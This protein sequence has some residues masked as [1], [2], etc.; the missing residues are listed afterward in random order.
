[1]LTY[2]NRLRGETYQK[3]FI[4]KTKIG[5]FNGKNVI[6][7]NNEKFKKQ[8]FKIY[9]KI[10][11]KNFKKIMKYNL[12]IEKKIILMMIRMILMMIFFI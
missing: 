11:K 7:K 10:G 4:Q 2:F 9:V 5:H 1:M 8:L 6:M 12:K 3:K